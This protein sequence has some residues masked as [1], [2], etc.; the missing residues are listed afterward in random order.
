M[1]TTGRGISGVISTLWLRCTI[2]RSYLEKKKKKR[3]T[4]R[5]TKAHWNRNNNE[6]RFTPELSFALC[7]FTDG[8]IELRKLVLAKLPESF[9]SR[10]IENASE[11]RIENASRSTGTSRAILPMLENKFICLSRSVQG[12]ICYSNVKFEFPS[13]IP[14]CFHLLDPNQNSVANCLCQDSLMRF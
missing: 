9:S 6:S 5:H 10:G 8:V 13:P 14:G 1:C 3:I 11:S 4:E 2:F 12:N 7:K